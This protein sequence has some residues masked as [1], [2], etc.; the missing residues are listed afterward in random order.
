MFGFNHLFFFSTLIKQIGRDCSK[1]TVCLTICILIFPKWIFSFW[2]CSVVVQRLDWCTQ[3]VPF[4]NGIVSLTHNPLDS[5]VRIS[6]SRHHRYN[7]PDKSNPPPSRD[8]AVSQVWFKSFQG[9]GGLTAVPNIPDAPGGS[10]YQSGADSGTRLGEE[11]R[12]S[13]CLE[14]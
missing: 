13:V 9:V 7:W 14:N 8:L 2:F 1:H 10:R 12:R 6:P 11:K 5:S 4:Q 3:S